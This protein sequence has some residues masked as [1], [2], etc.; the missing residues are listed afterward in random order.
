[1]V[2]CKVTT[3]NGPIHVGD[4]LVTFSREGYAMKGTDRS[5]MLG[6]IVSKALQPLEKGSASIEVL[7]TLQ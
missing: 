4:L 1:M 6:A 2:P 7:V 5:K 3:Q